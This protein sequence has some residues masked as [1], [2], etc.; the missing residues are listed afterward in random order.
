VHAF[1]PDAVLAAANLVPPFF[2]GLKVQLFHGFSVDKRARERGHFRVRGLFDL[3]CTQGPDTTAPFLELAARHGHFRVIETGWP[4][5]DPLFRAGN[6]VL[7]EIR[8]AAAGRPIV[9]F[10]STFTER[11][12]A[13]PHLLPE[14][15]R[16][17][18]SGRWYWLVTLHP[19]CTPELQRSY[20]ALAG[21]HV[22]FIESEQLPLPL[23]AAAVLVADTSSIASEFL[24]LRR[25][26]VSFRH[27]VPAPHLSD[28]REPAQLEAAI[29]QAL[30]P[31]AA[32]LAAIERYAAR[33]H[34]AR[35]GRASERVLDAVHGCL[36]GGR[37]ALRRK[38]FNPLRR[39][40]LRWRFGGALR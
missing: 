17:S 31:P 29:E 28:V 6:G 30:S 22:R 21:K 7:A 14:I 24:C 18:A 9:A 36:A 16:L 34:P 38:P 8:A 15:A 4:K 3:Y 12:S 25:P 37:S 19:K 11:L 26:V 5:L 10:G 2:P 27:R 35:D 20:R 13:A 23:A 39:L 33:I 1:R 40:Q 32:M